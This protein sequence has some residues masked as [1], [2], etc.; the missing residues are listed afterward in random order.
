VDNIYVDYRVF[1]YGSRHPGIVQFVMCDGSVHSIPTTIDSK[2]LGY[3]SNVF[4][5]EAFTM[6]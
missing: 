4:D 3:L 5:G 1:I 2:V 6:P